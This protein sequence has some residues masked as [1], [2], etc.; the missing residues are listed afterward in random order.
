MYLM[1]EIVILDK[2]QG[3]LNDQFK[4]IQVMRHTQVNFI[5]IKDLL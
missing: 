3:V 5:Y 2:G 4:A 1:L